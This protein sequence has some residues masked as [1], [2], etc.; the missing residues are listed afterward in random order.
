[1]AGSV[2]FEPT[3]GGLSVVYGFRIR[4]NQPTLPTPR[5]RWTW[6]E[7]NPRR[8]MLVTAPAPTTPI[9]LCAP[10]G[11]ITRRGRRLPLSQPEPSIFQA[12][13]RHAGLGEPGQDG[14]YRI[15][16]H[17]RV[18]FGQCTRDFRGRPWLSRASQ[19][20]MCSRPDGR[21]PGAGLS[22]WFRLS[23][24]PLGNPVSNDASPES[25][26]AFSVR[27]RS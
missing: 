9:S 4:R 15:G 12:R 14:S 24:W 5:K 8:I 2:G 16:C 21:H 20:F 27:Q 22:Q 3:D 26:G 13:E 18:L 6:R 19:I 7:L 1:M 25:D 17:L 23:L 11:L 10:G